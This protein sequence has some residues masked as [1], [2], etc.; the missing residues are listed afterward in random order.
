VSRRGALLFAAGA[1]I[2]LGEAVLVHLGT[3]GPPLLGRGPWVL[4]LIAGAWV[5]YGAAA[6]CLLRTPR[7]AA[8]GAA[9]V[10]A[11]V[12]R[13][14]ALAPQA[15][16]SDDL[17]RYAWDG[18]VQAAGIDPYRYPPVAAPLRLRDPD[19]LWPP[20]AACAA[21]RVGPGCAI[22]NRAK[23]R[24]IYPP[25]A[26]LWFLGLHATGVSR[27]RDLGLEAAGLVVDLAVLAALLALLRRLGRDVR[28]VLLWALCPLP[29]LEAVANAHVDGLAVLATLG[30]VALALRPRR[31]R[32]RGGTR[33]AAATGAVLGMAVLVKL[34][35]LL[36]FPAL[37]RGRLRV[38]AAGAVALVGVGAAGYLPHVLAV[39]TRVLG[40]LPGYLR[41]ERYDAGTRYLL[42]G[43][44]GLRGP[45]A[46]AVALA[47]LAAA[48][49]AVTLRRPDPVTGCLWLYATLLL[50]AT[51]VQPW[52][53]LSLAALAV[54]AGRWEWQLVG[55]AGY[56]PYFAAV[57][58]GD[59]AAAGRTSYGL[60]ALAIL[61]VTLA[62]RPR[63]RDP[64]ALW[65]AFRGSTRTDQL[66]GPPAA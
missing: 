55:F 52:Y 66:A 23:V 7:R 54:L 2:G 17:Y 43:L 24:T 60:A 16:L 37:V 25:A 44:V 20:P 9:V 53:A 59:I 51:P 62:R 49:A 41:E 63:L 15:L 30:A 58:D 28:L 48:V 57:F 18:R 40:Y 19:W 13:V 61:A 21:R 36:L 42:L 34:Y 22:L 31:Q 29:V 38:V 64:F 26:E 33:R 12:L 8:V 50:V 14:A 56:P 32:R 5:A 10:L 4:G 39:G 65:G 35:P 6:A 3:R 1:A 45:A 11:V 27:A 47:V 46:T